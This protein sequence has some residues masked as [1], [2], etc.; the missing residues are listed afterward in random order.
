MVKNLS[1]FKRLFTFGCSYTSHIYPTWTNVLSKECT[2]AIFYNLALPGSG[3][4]LIAWRIAEANN[5]YKFNE[6]DLVIV[7]WTTFCREDRF[8]NGMWQRYGNVFNN[9]YYDHCFLKYADPDGYAIQ[10]CASMQL[11]TT[12]LSYL[13]NTTINL[14]SF[15]L[16]DVETYKDTYTLSIVNDL[17]KKY[18]HLWEST[19]TP[20]ISFTREDQTLN[21]LPP[22]SRGITYKM[23][24]DSLFIDEHPNLL[25]GYAY[26]KY[27]DFPLTDL[28][29]DYAYRETKALTEKLRYQSEIYEMYK[30]DVVANDRLIEDMFK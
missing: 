25:A 14:L 5:I 29:Y 8:V 3:N 17:T 12:F 15:P 30:E 18:G 21:L 1:K 28:S 23:N 22:K 7:M 27:L 26:L 16:F 20:Y 24:D 9:H 19:P 6:Q 13:P 4:N 10:N 2:N 11:A